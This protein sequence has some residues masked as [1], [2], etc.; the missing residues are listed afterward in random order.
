MGMPSRPRAA[1]ARASRSSLLQRK[2][3]V[4]FEDAYLL[5]SATGDVRIGQVCNPNNFP[6]TIRVVFPKISPTTPSTLS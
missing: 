3:D 1:S 6:A 4:S 5:M 2:L